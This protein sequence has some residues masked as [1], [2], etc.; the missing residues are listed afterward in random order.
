MILG[1]PMNTFLSF[2]MIA[3]I[4]WMVIYLTKGL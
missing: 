3:W 4:F 1:F 2:C